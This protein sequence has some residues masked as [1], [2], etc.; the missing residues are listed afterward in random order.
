MHALAQSL[1][2][3]LASHVAA[4]LALEPARFLLAG[5]FASGLNWLS[6]F[7][8]SRF[9]PF[10]AAV[11]VSY[12][13]GMTFGFVTY[14]AWVFPGSCVPVKQQVCRFFCVN[15]V[16]LAVVTAV[17]SL[18]VRVLTT[19]GIATAPAEAL[20]HAVGIGAGAV[21]SFVGHRGLT[22]VRAL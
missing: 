5:G 10:D 21:G 8:L 9:L 4:I 20:A 13:F 3:R 15:A 7:G 16:S 22:F 1:R 12:M 11:V 17:S 6:R 18:L 14:R 19:G 2:D